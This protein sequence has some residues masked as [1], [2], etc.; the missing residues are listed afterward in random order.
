MVTCSRYGNHAAQS[1][2]LMST[3]ER[4]GR[5]RGQAGIIAAMAVAAMLGLANPGVGAPA[6]ISLVEWP[7]HPTA[8]VE[9][10]LPYPAGQ[11]VLAH[12]T[13]HL[14]WLNAMGAKARDADRHSNAWTNAYAVGYWLSGAPDDL[15]ELLRALSGVFDPL[16]LPQD[17]A[18]EERGILLREYDHRMADNPDAKADAALDAFLY[19][20][21]RMAASLIG[22][23]AA[24]GA[25][26]YD[27]ARALH[28]ETHRPGN[29]RLVVIGDIR[30]RQVRRALRQ[31]GWPRATGDGAATLPPAFDLAAPDRIVLRD[32]EPDA[33][34]RLI[35]RKVVT[36][37]EPMPFDLL[38]AQAALLGDIL[39]SNL[40]GG[41]AGPLRFDAAIAS[42]FDV[43]V[44]PIDADNVEIGFR[45]APDRGVSLT[46]LQA[47][48]EA[49][50]AASAAAGIPQATY[51]RAL[52]RFDFWPDWN[53]PAET[54]AWMADYMLDRVSALR[55]PL[56]ERALRHLDRGL[57]L[58]TTN[59]LLRQLAGD[60]RTAIA[61]IG[62]EDSFE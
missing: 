20:G 6:G 14:A 3:T 8:R 22:T 52:A 25:L 17:F 12:Y 30:P 56:A 13:E 40:P 51:D 50:L 48:F 1:F 42:R 46:D 23:P 36:L 24:I 18:A 58:E 31:A 38:E 39:Y 19:A 35:W 47:A 44:W 62:P 59:A 26:D 49:A 28:A 11:E 37:P 10:V 15:P 5:P 60:G 32:P 57:S 54:A 33:A 34:P 4:T 9:I 27:A 61:F 43:D 2:L 45:A 21:N 16:D 29:A 55:E 7:G 53:D 41:L